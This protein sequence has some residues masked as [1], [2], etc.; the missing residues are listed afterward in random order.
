MK[1][2]FEVHPIETAPKDR[3]IMLFE[4]GT[5]FVSQW[6]VSRDFGASGRG[7]WYTTPG[8]SPTHWAE[9]ESMAVPS[10]I[11]SEED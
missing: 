2:T 10:C 11:T 6:I 7:F 8:G 3:E 5:W 1:I 9:I 4:A